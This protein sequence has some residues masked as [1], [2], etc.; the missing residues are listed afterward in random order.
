MG[1][2]LFWIESLAAGLVFMALVTAGTVRWNRR[3]IRRTVLALAVLLLL[4]PAVLVTGSAASLRFEERMS[5]VPFFYPLS[6]TV[7]L[8]AG[9]G[10]VLVQGL[11]RG[12]QTEP[13]ARSWSVSKL[14]L[15]LGALVIVSWIT[16]T[17][18]DLAV[19]FQLASVRAEA[20][21]KALSR[22][23]PR[24]PDRDNA[25]R[26]YQEA[27]AA[28]PPMKTPL[29]FWRDVWDRTSEDPPLPAFDPRN[30]NLREFLQAREPGMA[31]LR[32]AAAMP[33]CWFEHDYSAGI[34]MLLPEV[35]SLHEGALLLA[36]DALSKAAHGQSAPALD[37]LAAVFGIARHIKEGEPFLISVSLGHSLDQVGTRA[38]EEVL[39][40]SPPRADE[41]GRLS[42]SDHPSNQRLLQRAC[43]MEEPLFG[44]PAFAMLAAPESTLALIDWLRLGGGHLPTLVENAL[45]YRVFLLT[46][47][48]T[49]YRQVMRELQRLAARPY[50]ESHQGWEEYALSWRTDRRGLMTRLITPATQHFATM[51]PEGDALHHLARLALA[52]TACRA[53]KG[54]Y[55]D[56]L[57]ELVPEFLSAIPLDPFDG[58]PLRTKRDEKGILLYSVGPNL[59]DDGGAL[60]RDRQR[61]MQ[62]GDI[63]FR[64]P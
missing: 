7:A 23:P 11:R 8:T 50:Y 24:P 15:V 37:D 39:A 38:L 55:P 10:L 62:E 64:L 28:L 16:I 4:G 58:Q 63:V 57:Q 52:M 25:A 21:A 19:K 44:L 42:L 12:G 40:L 46:D 22:M 56:Q 53:K 9:A 33:D 41:L 36:H 14:A 59:K 60:P 47:D 31:L 51:A 26:V 6:W 34:G 29:P 18:L 48:L 54:K 17:S 49:A 13:A 43:E 3:W 20:G 5:S 61:R 1:H 27:F 30:E 45:I 35:G 32:R 2:A